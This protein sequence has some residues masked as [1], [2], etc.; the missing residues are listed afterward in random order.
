[1]SRLDR[2]PP[3]GLGRPEGMRSI[4]PVVIDFVV[5]IGFTLALFSFGAVLSFFSGAVC[6]VE[7]Q[8]A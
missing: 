7:T 2:R 5:A 1:M 4:G 3:A 8:N 6:Q